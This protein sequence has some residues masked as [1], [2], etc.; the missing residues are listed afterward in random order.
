LPKGIK[1]ADA[2]LAD[3]NSDLS[4]ATA[5]LPGGSIRL[6][7]S[8]FSLKDL[9]VND[10]SFLKLTLTADDSFSGNDFITLDCIKFSERDMTLHT[11]DGFVIPVGNDMSSLEQVYSVIRIYTDGMNV[12][13]DSPESGTAKI[14]TIAGITQDREV[15]PGHN[16]IPMDN[17][18]IYIVTL[19][20]STAKLYLK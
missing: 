13:I 20:G 16:V 15:H 6:L 9:A 5:E 14:V 1:L 12:I 8:S 18:G 17:S 2:S 7:A 4:I 3:G 11:I 19:N 10:A